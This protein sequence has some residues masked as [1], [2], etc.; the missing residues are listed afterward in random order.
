MPSTQPDAEALEPPQAP[1][2]PARTEPEA[3]PAGGQRA[4][5]LGLLA[6][7]IVALCVIGWRVARRRMLRAPNHGLFAYSKL[8]LNP[9]RADADRCIAAVAPLARAWKGDAAFWAA[10]FP[11]VGPDGNIDLTKHPAMVTY[12][13]PLG[14]GS[15]ARRVR[16]DSIEKFRFGPAGVR[17]AHVDGVVEPWVGVG[18][19]V[20]PRCGIRKLAG[21]L[22]AKGLV[23]GKTVAISFDPKLAKLVGVPS[24]HVVGREPKISAW[25]A[26]SDCH[27][28]KE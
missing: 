6:L 1:G 27:L 5:L 12:F 17:L 3:Q 4:L 25:Y 10:T 2:P 20:A 22:A 28:V 9:Q 24:W 14:V 26:L 8:D 11:A 18:V 7:V 15:P 19:P 13:S 23:A 16:R 21:L